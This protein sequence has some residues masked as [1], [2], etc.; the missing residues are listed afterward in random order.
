MLH[1]SSRQSIEV[2]AR[3]TTVE[4]ALEYCALDQEPPAQVSPAH[5]PP[6]N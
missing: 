2:E 1:L 4:R 3:M 6:P 5:R